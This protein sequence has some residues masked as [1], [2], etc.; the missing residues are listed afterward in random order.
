MAGASR[1]GTRLR[2]A[3]FL[4]VGIGDDRPRPGR[5]RDERVPRPRSAARLTR[6]SR[7]AATQGAPKDIVVVKV[8]DKTFSDLQK[9]CGGLPARPRQADHAAEEGRREGDRLR[10]P[11]HG[12][13]R[14]RGGR[15]Q[16]DRGGRQARATSSSPR[17]R[18]TRTGRRT[19]SAATRP[20]AAIRARKSATGTSL[21][22]P[23]ATTGACATRSRS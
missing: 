10:R 14:R 23:A 12:A 11:V 20:S 5:V 18:S 21:R 4:A 16:A 2:V 22:T 7:S 19:S 3:L 6:G 17:P 9:R 13:G 15:Q 1:S 8:D